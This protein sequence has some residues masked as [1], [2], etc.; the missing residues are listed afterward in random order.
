[1]RHNDL[2]TYGKS[3]INEKIANIQ[4]LDP[5][6]Y[7]SYGDSAYSWDT[8]LRGRHDNEPN[9]DRQTCENIAMSSCRETIEWN[10]GDIGRYF[11][12]LDFHYRL[13]LRKQPV[14]SMYLIGMIL[15]NAYC[16]MNANNT[17]SYF[18]FIPPT[19]DDWTKQGPMKE[20]GVQPCELPTI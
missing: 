3:E 4:R 19:L 7:K 9:S 8:H 20:N 1:M 17:A 15:R 14:G 13:K 16:T 6:Q 12:L 18:N 10:Y 2:Y 5:F 11:P